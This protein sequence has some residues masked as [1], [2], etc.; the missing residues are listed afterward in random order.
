MAE[1]EEGEGF[2]RERRIR[3]GR[4]RCKP[5]S[6]DNSSADPD[7]RCL[8]NAPSESACGSNREQE[9]AR[10]DGE[11]DMAAQSN[12]CHDAFRVELSIL[13]CA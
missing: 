8:R 5:R 6:R 10:A 2:R 11:W 3:Y 9:G 13:Q 4:M 7:G 12:F 1:R